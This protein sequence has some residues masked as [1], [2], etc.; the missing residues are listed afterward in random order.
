MT[1]ILL[2][3][4]YH[5]FNYVQLYWFY[6]LT[7]LSLS[8]LV[9]E[10]WVGIILFSWFYRHFNYFCPFKKKGICPLILQFPTLSSKW[11]FGGTI[12]DVLLA[13]NSMDTASCYRS[14]TISFERI[15]YLIFSCFA[16]QRIKSN[17]G[18]IQISFNEK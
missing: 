18:V 8:T 17:L 2:R 6:F 14:T 13:A 11:N 15:K 16:Y 12:Y 10:R 4:N 9:R 7:Q 1:S 5:L 3:P